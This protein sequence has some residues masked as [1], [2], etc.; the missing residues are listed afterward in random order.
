M[1]K[2]TILFFILFLRVG[3]LAAQQEKITLNGYV[4]D[5]SSGE[6]LLGAS[7]VVKGTPEGAVTNLYGFY[8]IRLVP[9]N[10]KL[11]FSYMGYETRLI[12]L[13]IEKDMDYSIEL[14]PVNYSLE[15]IEVQAIANDERILD[16]GS[17]IERVSMD[18]LRKMPKLMGEVDIIRNIQ[19]LPGISTVGEGTS[20]FNVRGGGADENLILLDEAPVFN[21]AHVMGFFSVFNSDAIKDVKIY[22]GGLPA[23]YGGRLS[24]VLDVRQLEGNQKKLGVKGG[25]G[26]LSS[27]L[28]VEGPIKKDRSSFL[29]SGRRSYL[30]VFSNLSKDEELQN[31][32]LYFYDL[33]AK[34]NHKISEKDRLF[35]SYYSGKDVMNLGDLFSS[36]WG[37]NTMTLRWNHVF[38]PRLFTN[39]TLTNSKYFYH[40]KGN[41]GPDSWD[42]VSNILNR[43]LKMDAAYFVS[44]SRTIDFGLQSN[45]QAYL[46]GT[47]IPTGEK[48]AVN[49]LEMQKE[50]ALESGLYLSWDEKFN[51]K[52]KM[53][54]G[55]RY[56]DFRRLGGSQF[57]YR[58][59]TKEREAIIDTLN[60]SRSETMA[61]YRG[62]EPRLNLSFTPNAQTAIKA[63]F[64]RANQFV[65]LISNTNAPSPIDI[66]KPSNAY[67]KP[68]QVDQLSLALVRGIKD[69]AF[70]LVVETYYKN[71]QRILEFKDG[72]QLL[73]NEAL[74]T[75]ILE[76]VGRAYGLEA[77][78]EKKKGRFTGR[79]SYTLAR[80][81]RKV[82]GINKGYW[83]RANFDKPHDLSIFGLYQLNKKWDFSANFAIASGRPFTQPV[84]KYELDGMV[85][86]IM[87]ERNAHRIPTYHRLD[88]AANLNPEGKRG[89]WSFGLYN[90]YARRNAY[91]IF[92]RQ[93]E[94]STQTEAVRLSILGS[95]I[96]SI[97]YNFKF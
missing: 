41:Q 34:I 56:A 50:Y 17:G 79:I 26:L 48:S 3:L 38:N 27:R 74:E 70:E 57:I 94:N 63:S 95:I 42:W 93:Q 6:E 72:G 20:G 29:I 23:Q 90:V 97:T 39:I 21:A 76:G 73:F 52:W 77:S 8:S 45:L 11:Q 2:C 46:P 24:S 65:H 59:G 60:F 15:T 64:H 28:T 16:I 7:V 5:A 81:E 66:W 35:F 40:I 19:L 58:N 14:L 92:F 96:P 37:N 87:G 33:N 78:I 30:D 61:S 43:T 18:Q 69:N 22:K 88:I 44:P 9:G 62:I 82:Q 55:V 80:S 54:L 47:M 10:Y 12:E 32:D 49:K 25:I 89:S 75:E 36:S 67:L 86:P 13:S 4:R 71:Y 85:Q 68:A 53:Q 31:T 1:K 51:E 83:Y 84:G 91:S